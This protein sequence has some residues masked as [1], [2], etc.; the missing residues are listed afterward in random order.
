MLLAELNQLLSK[1]AK[2]L[3]LPTFRSEVSPAG[4]NL[5]WLKK[6]MPRNPRCPQRIQELVQKSIQELTRA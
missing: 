1:H 2:D 3:G 6:M 5:Q 4:G